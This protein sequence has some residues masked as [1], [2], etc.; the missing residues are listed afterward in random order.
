[1]NLLDKREL[2]IQ[3]ISLREVNLTEFAK[4]AATV[5]GLPEDKVAVID[6]RHGEVALD[7]LLPNIS[8]RA[9]FGKEKLLL[10]AI[11]EISGVEL[12]SGAHIHSRG[13]LGAIGLDENTTARALRLTKRMSRNLG[14]AKVVVFPTGFELIAKNIEDTNTP[15]LCKIFSEAGFMPEPGHCLPD[16][17]STLAAALREAAEGSRVVITTGGVGAED[18]DFSVEAVLALDPGAAAPYLI[19]FTK[20]NGRHIKDGIRIAV[21][22]YKGCLLVALP[23]P[24]D[25]VRL[26]APHLARSIKQRLNKD[27]IA[28][29][30]AA[31]LKSK[32]IRHEHS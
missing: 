6:V 11:A 29:K 25:E 9:F 24:H 28:D 16:N 32:F 1:M 7:I 2:R 8:P 3:G 18:K 12:H 14:N 15:Y 23:G 21:G 19:R 5:L 10:G 22:E 27:E 13:I 17:L 31:V 26:T 30:L 4:T 20:G